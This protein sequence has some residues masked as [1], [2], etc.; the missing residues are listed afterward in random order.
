MIHK[1]SL[2][3]PWFE[4]VKCGLKRYEAGLYDE[5][6][7]F[8]INDVIIISSSINPDK[9][10]I[11]AIVSEKIHYKN[12]KHAIDDLGVFNLL[13]VSSFNVIL[14]IEYYKNKYNYENLNKYDVIVLD[15]DIP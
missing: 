10:P 9:E 1:L 7:K 15:L 2:D 5:F 12:F 11:K 6:N 8:N 13:P 4:L 14:A 3:D